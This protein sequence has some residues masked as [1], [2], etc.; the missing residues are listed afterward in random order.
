MLMLDYTCNLGSWHSAEQI[1][2]RATANDRELS[3]IEPR[4]RMNDKIRQNF[5]VNT[6]F[7]EPE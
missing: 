6:V 7:G 5:K 2:G 3:P 1:F 4:T